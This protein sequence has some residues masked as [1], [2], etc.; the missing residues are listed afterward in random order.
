MVLI[1]TDPCYLEHDTGSHPESPQRLKSISKMLSAC[2]FKDRLSPG[3][4]RSATLEEISLVHSRE[5]ILSVEEFA[6]QGGG[7]IEADTILSP[8]SYNVAMK[9]TGAALEAVDRVLG[10][11]NKTAV[12]LTRPPGHHARPE[13]AMGFCLFNNIAVAAEY[14][15]QRHKLNRI[16]IVDWDVHHGNGTQEIF[17]RK[18]NIH[19]LSAH[20][21]PFYPGTGSE[22]ETGEGHGL[23]SIW[24]LPVAY[25]TRPGD[26]RDKFSAILERALK[27]TKP[28]LILISAGFDAHR[29][30]PIGSLDLSVED[31]S[32]LTKLVLDAADEYCEGRVV[33]LLEGGYNVQALADSVEAHLEAFVNHEKK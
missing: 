30:D 12:C 17:Y 28:E 1:Y 23:G 29:D 32:Y 18:E 13:N 5:Y 24:N 20:R 6:S 33:S 9:A 21:F 2:S 27:K 25:G 4:I 3:K 8:E 15:C 7:R 22:S 19:F 14:A 31:F 10:N 26:Y 11:I 16:L